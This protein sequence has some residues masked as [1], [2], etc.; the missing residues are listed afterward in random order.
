MADAK[1]TAPGDLAKSFA[2]R[3]TIPDKKKDD[4]TSFEPKGGFS[5]ADDADTPVESTPAPPKKETESEAPT[6]HTDSPADPGSASMAQG[7][8]AS[9]WLNG[10]GLDEPEFDVN[11]KLADLQ[12]DPNNPLY[13]IKDFGDLKM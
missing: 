5:W 3:L 1:E 7:D 13:S 10:S 11:V 2:D 9:T 4:V 6:S 8:G 12:D